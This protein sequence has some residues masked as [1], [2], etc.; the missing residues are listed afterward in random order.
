M[1]DRK[2]VM[3]SNVELSALLAESY[4]KIEPHYRTENVILMSDKLKE[5]KTRTKGSSLLDMGCGTGFVI[6]IAK[7]YFENVYGIDISWEMLEKVNKNSE[8]GF[9]KL[10]NC[11][12]DDTSFHD[13][14]IDV[15]IAYSVLHHL[16]DITSTVRE[17]YRVLRRGGIF[18]S[19]LDPN[20]Y[21][22]SVVKQFNS[23]NVKYALR[24]EIDKLNGETDDVLYQMAEPIKHIYGGFKE[25]NLIGIF[26]DVGFSNIKINYY[27]FLGEGSLMYSKMKDDIRMYLKESLPLSRSMFKYLEIE[28]TK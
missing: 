27:W 21:F 1:F 24:R 10:V 14:S 11:S 22:Y 8:L 12:I 16:Y 13:D 15:C 19:A 3:S 6:D 28:A 5:L 7:H 25:E 20:F 17:A 23:M 9:V 2:E 4:N 18:Y 26:S